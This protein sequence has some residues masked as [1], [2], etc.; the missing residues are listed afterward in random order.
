[1]LQDDARGCR[2]DLQLEEIILLVNIKIEEIL[3]SAGLDVLAAMFTHESGRIF[4]KKGG[5]EV[6]VVQRSAGK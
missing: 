3:L 5:G 1:M 4:A 2:V 6:W